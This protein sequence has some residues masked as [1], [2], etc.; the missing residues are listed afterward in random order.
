MNAYKAHEI[1]MWTVQII[2]PTVL[3]GVYIWN[4]TNLFKNTKAKIKAVMN[5]KKNNK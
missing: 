1:R 3:L 2:I 5:K 4:E